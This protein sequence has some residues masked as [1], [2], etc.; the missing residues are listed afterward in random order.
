M[1]SGS[2]A[3]DDCVAVEMQARGIPG[4]SLAIVR[5][6]QLVSVRA[7]GKAEAGEST[8]VTPET[9]F[10]AASVSKPVAAA[11]AL[12]L[13]QQGKLALDEDVN[14]RLTGW[15]VPE[16]EF[17]QNEKATVRRI[18]S[19][20][21]GFTV[22]GF[23]GYPAGQ[24]VPDL[25]AILDRVGKVNTS[26][27]R[28]T[29][30][31]G[32]EWRYSGGGYTVLQKL[33]TDVTG[34]PFPSL[35]RQLLF[36]PLKME[37]STFEQ[38]LPAAWRASAACGY[39]KQGG[40]VPGRCNVFPEMAAAGLW[41]TPSDLALFIIALQQ[42][43]AGREEGVIS[44]RIARWMTTPVLKGCGLGLGVSGMANEFFG[45]NGR[46]SGFDSMV[47][48]S[49]N[50]GVAIMIN[51][52]DDTGVLVRICN[53]AWKVAALNPPLPAPNRTLDPTI[54]SSAYPDYVG[55]YDYGAVFAEITTENGKLYSQITGQK[56]FEIFPSGPDA[57]FLKVV[58][59]G[60]LFERD[61]SGVVAGL[62]HTQNGRTFRAPRLSENEMPVL[63]IETLEDY[64]GE[65]Q[66]QRKVLA[67]TRQGNQLFAQ[68][69]GQSKYPI[70]PKSDHEFFLKIVP[71]RLEFIRGEDG[72]V[73]SA[74]SHQD[75]ITRTGLRLPPK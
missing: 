60:I 13:V 51:T 16:N 71:A 15:K 41:T 26:R 7:Y 20:T 53:D 43:L 47:R 59:A 21:A 46:L 62:I 66:Y 38:P 68:L 61:Q 52:N 44:P 25:T 10:A 74:V 8:A 28:V 22:H 4:L 2:D 56:R 36:D 11:G 40:N 14:V 73:A 54:D 58:E 67:V 70:F 18:L 32:S 12:L 45:H 5:D 35:M 30:I 48:C 6:G 27:V 72:K 37:R 23:P 64:V 29:S 17:T 69:T 39:L 57:F 63:P 75:G 31:P 65:Y 42:G 33:M 55:R 9:L 24:P 34:Q 1:A 50:G 19:H 49:A 3:L